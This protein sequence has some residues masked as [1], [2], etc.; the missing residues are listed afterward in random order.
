MEALRVSELLLG[1]YHKMEVK[2]N[3]CGGGKDV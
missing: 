1:K 3:D 2:R